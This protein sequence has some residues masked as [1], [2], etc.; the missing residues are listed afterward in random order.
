MLPDI[1]DPQMLFLANNISKMKQKTSLGSRIIEVH[2]SSSLFNG[3][4]GSGT[5]NLRRYI[6]ENDLLEAIV[7]L[8]EKMFY[9]TDIGTFLWIVTNKKEEKRKGKVQLIDATTMKSSLKKNIGEKNSEITPDIRRRI[10]EIYFA[11]DEADPKYS[12]VFENTEFG[13]YAVDVQRPLRLSVD[14]SEENISK[15]EAKDSDLAGVLMEYIEQ[16]GANSCADYNE[17]IERVSEIADTKNIKL[18][19]KRKKLIRDIL[20][21]VDETAAPVKDAKGNLE[22]DKNLKD[23][24][25]VPMTYPGGIDGYWENEVRPYAQDSWIESDSASIGYEL[26]F[27][28][29]FYK[30]VEV[31]SAEDIILDIQSIEKDTDGLLAAITGGMR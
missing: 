9:N 2:N 6:I 24:E 25:Q 4:A 10:L 8:P 30:P 29:Y 18:T 20:T 19:A 27:T 7:A 23:T 1:G 12:K 3:N 13:Y 14:L 11:F 22:A 26:S 5:S 28:K 16:A 15:I 21:N 17:F 31:R